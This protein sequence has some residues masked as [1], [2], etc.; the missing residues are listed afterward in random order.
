M[1]V[2]VT[3]A[4]GMLGGAVATA[5]V[6]RGDRVRVLQRRPSGLTGVDERCGDIT[7]PVA[8][9]AAVEGVDAVVHLAA[10]VSM[11]GPW[12]QFEH[13]NID[14]TAT[15]IGAARAAGVTRFVQVSSPSVAHHGAGLVGVDAEPADPTRARGDYARSK[16]SAEVLALAVDSADFAVVAVRPHLVWGPGTP[17]WSPGSSNGPEPAGWPWSAGGP[18]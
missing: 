7:D 9:R 17:N 1:K 18:P 11:T 8:V 16:A 3:G 10:K 4:S 2:L 14:G 13:I 15:L 12:A 5:L 6:R